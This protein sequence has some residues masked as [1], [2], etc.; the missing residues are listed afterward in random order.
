[1]Q[2]TDIEGTAAS[3]SIKHFD[4]SDEQEY[5]YTFSCPDNVQ[6][7]DVTLTG[8][9]P[10]AARTEAVSNLSAS[11]SFRYPKRGVHQERREESKGGGSE[12]G[13][14]AFNFPHLS[15]SRIYRPELTTRTPRIPSTW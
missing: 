3:T 14:C 13:R 15:Y 5:T 1:M 11:A 6:T 12:C 4:L 2:T 8:T 9:V 10:I 7:V